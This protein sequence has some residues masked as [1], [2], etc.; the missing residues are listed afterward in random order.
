MYD[1]NR[2]H[3]II[4]LSNGKIINIFYKDNAGIL[5]SVLN[6]RNQWTEPLVLLKNCHPDFSACVDDNDNIHVLCQ[7]NNGNIM[8]IYSNNN[9]WNIETI[10]KSK[11]PSPYN[12]YLNLVY[13][14]E[15]LIFL[16]VIE[17]GGRKILSYQI[18]EKDKLTAPKVIDYVPFVN[19]PFHVVLSPNNSLHVVYKFTESKSNHIGF[20][21]F[22]KEEDR[23]G[24][25]IPITNYKGDSDL[26]SASSD[27]SGSIHL[28]WQKD[29]LQKYELMYSKYQ[30]LSE[31]RYMEIPLFT[32]EYSFELSSIILL[33]EQV[34]V[35]WVRDNNI[36]YCISEDGGNTWGKA[37]TYQLQGGR[38]VYCMVYRS[39][40]ENELFTSYINELPGNYSGGYKLA[41]AGDYIFKQKI[42][43]A[44]DFRYKLTGTLELL[45]KN[46]EDT[47]KSLENLQ[48]KVLNLESRKN[49]IEQEIE[50]INIKYDMLNSDLTKIR[51]IVELITKSKSITE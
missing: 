41:F 11:N 22:I 2:K 25:F 47:R 49:K 5:L 26:L 3:Y 30:P 46:M 24:E 21:T 40:F 31:N 12:K 9:D 29:A 13:F 48:T 45:A 14:Q 33:E 15:V 38:V 34:I 17:Y 19:K 8:Y 10:L 50:K 35:F 6:K 1:I 36:Y 43:G 51:N 4:K 7:D 42:V 18:K 44:E 32:A 16:F 39:T 23:W 28:L 20:R 37:S 27:I